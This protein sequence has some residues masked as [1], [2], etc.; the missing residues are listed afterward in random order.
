MASGYEDA[1]R[2]RIGR[3]RR[4]AEEV[5]AEGRSPR[6]PR[7]SVRSGRANASRFR[8]RGVEWRTLGMWTKCATIHCFCG[9]RAR[10][11]SAGSCGH[12]G[13]CRRPPPAV[14]F[15][16]PTHDGTGGGYLPVASAPPPPTCFMKIVRC[17]WDDSTNRHDHSATQPPPLSALTTCRPLS[18]SMGRWQMEDASS[19]PRSYLRSFS[20]KSQRP[21]CS[22]AAH[23]SHTAQKGL[24]GERDGGRAGGTEV[25]G[26]Y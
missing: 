15:R 26:L 1:V 6:R 4:S 14:Q 19:R 3:R 9:S 5:S 22:G 20:Q 18:K 13:S 10:M 16:P 11:I 21:Y 17:R 8:E 24:R 23:E 2:T 25:K 12:E 7:G